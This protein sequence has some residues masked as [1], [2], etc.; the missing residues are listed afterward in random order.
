MP[1]IED[2]TLAQIRRLWFQQDGAPP[3]FGSRMITFQVNESGAVDLLS[4][5]QG[6]PT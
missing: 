2:I 4:G 1:I 5:P 6:L 3:H